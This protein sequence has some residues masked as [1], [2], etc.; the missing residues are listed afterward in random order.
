MKSCISCGKEGFSYTMYHDFCTECFGKA[1]AKQEKVSKQ[2][3][4][5]IAILEEI[6]SFTAEKE[7]I[8]E[9]EQKIKEIRWR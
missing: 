5:E 4:K 9:Y 1:W 6:I 8:K 3:A 7:V 2:K